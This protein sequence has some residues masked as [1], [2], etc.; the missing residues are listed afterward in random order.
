[1]KQ[2]TAQAASKKDEP[3]DPYSRLALIR[4]V[5]VEFAR[6]IKS[7]PG[8][9]N[10]LILHPGK[11][12]DDS[13]L[14][15][16]LASHGAAINSGDNV[17]ITSLVFKDKEIIFALNGGGAR[18]TRWRDRIQIQAGGIPSL[19]SSGSTSAAA[20][21]A[22]RGSTIIL[23]FG[24][25]LPDMTPDELKAML[26]PVLDFSKEHSAAVQWVETLPPEMKK[27]IEEKRPAMGMTHEMVI[28]AIGKPDKKVRERT[29]DGVDTEDWIYGTP[30]AKTMFVTFVGDKV[31]RIEEFPN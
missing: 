19:S 16:E 5:D 14:K 4:F 27:A 25:P 24:R 17:Q 6:A 10:G 20:A 2:G 7:L 29:P 28:A 8:G 23:D 1:P 31:T 18:K 15:R 30:P 3:L 21:Q 26:A 12:L 13:T 11:P 9:K 22:G